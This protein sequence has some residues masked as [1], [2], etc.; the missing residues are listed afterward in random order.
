MAEAADVAPGDPAKVLVTGN[1]VPELVHFDR[2]FRNFLAKYRI[3][4][5]SFALARDGQILY[6]RGFGYADLATERPVFPD[7][8]FRIASISKCLTAIEVMRLVERGKLKLDTPILEI[9]GNSYGAPVDPR[10]ERITIRRL[11]QHTGGWDRD[12]TFDPMFHAIEIAREFKTDPPATPAMIIRS[13]LRKPLDFNPG[14]RYAYSNFGYCLLGRVI[15]RV[16]GTSYEEAIDRDVLVPLKIDSRDFRLG[17]S[18]IKDRASGEVSYYAGAFPKEGAVVGRPLGRKVELPYGA[19][20]HESLD[21]HGGW[22]AT[23]SALVQVGLSLDNPS[24]RLKPESI[25]ECF[26]RPYGF[27]GFN[28]NRSPRETYYG[29]GWNVRPVQNADPKG[30]TATTW[31]NGSLPGTL[32]YLVRRSDGFT[33]AV[34]FNTR[35]GSKKEPLGP[36]IDP[37]IHEAVDVAMSGAKKK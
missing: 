33:W 4:G 12:A 7:S 5:A 29:L 20:S 1:Y 35:I 28:K 6:A 8:L 26:A 18:L 19:W 31:H 24:P 37:L 27:A 2:L 15:E 3:P 32:G 21:A 34:L 22:I 30:R 36:L 14:E 13:M 9:I 25:K 17:K 23:A 10:W 11:L 16:T